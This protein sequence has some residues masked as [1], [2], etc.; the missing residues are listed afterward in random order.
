MAEKSFWLAGPPVL[1]LDQGHRCFQG[2]SASAS[3]FLNSAKIVSDH[4]NVYIDDKGWD[5]EL[6]G[7]PLHCQVAMDDP[8]LSRFC[9]RRGE[10]TLLTVMFP[11]YHTPCRGFPRSHVTSV[12]E[13]PKHKKEFTIVSLIIQGDLARTHYELARLCGKI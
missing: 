3:D 2:G 6:F 4:L 9:K 13:L 11:R 1:C 10:Q 12:R 5:R 8:S 7:L